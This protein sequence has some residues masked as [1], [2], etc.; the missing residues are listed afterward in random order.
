MR[1]AVAL[2]TV[3]AVVAS[4]SGAPVAADDDPPPPQVPINVQLWTP[5]GTPP[6]VM[7]VEPTTGQVLQLTEMTGGDVASQ[8]FG[9]GQPGVVCLG[10]TGPVNIESESNTSRLVVSTVAAPAL[11]WIADEGAQAVAAFYDVPRDDRVALYGRDEIRAYMANRLLDIV[12]K[13]AYGRTLTADEQRALDYL[14]NQ[15]L[16]LDRAVATAAYREYQ[17]YKAQG[18]GYSPPPAPSF[19]ASPVPLPDAVRTWC[20]S[21]APGM[22]GVF[23]APMPGVDEFQAWGF[24]RAA[25]DLGLDALANPAFRANMSDVIRAGVMAGGAVVAGG[26]AAVTAALVGASEATAT[27]IAG[28]VAP[29]SGVAVSFGVGAAAAVVAVV[30]VAVIALALSIW[31][32]VE[33]EQIGT[34]ITERM[35]AAAA[36]T[37]PF[38]LAA[39][40]TANAGRSLEADRATW[41]DDASKPLYRRSAGYARLVELVTRATMVRSNGS[42]REDPTGI[43]TPNAT[44]P[45]DHRFRVTDASGTVSFVDQIQLPTEGGGTATLRFSRGW[46]VVSQGGG[47]P[48]PALDVGYVDADGTP[49]FATRR[50]DPH[51]SGQLFAITRGG[52]SA[53]VMTSAL[54]Y[55]DAGGGLVTAQIVPPAATAPLG[56]RP[57]VAGSLLPGRVHNLRPNPVSADGRFNLDTFVDDYDYH[58]TVERLDET[59]GAWVA[60]VGVTPV[61]VD[62][63][64][65]YGGAFT[66]TRVG[67]YRARA[68]MEHREGTFP[69]TSGVVE[70]S[71]RAPEIELLHADLVDDHIANA[72]T[73]SVQASES[74]PGDHVT[75]AVQWPGE[76]GSDEPGPIT[77]AEAD[78]VGGLPCATP[79]VTLTHP[80]G[81]LTDLRGDVTVTVTNSHGGA[82]SRKV[83]ITTP[84]RPSFVAP[85]VPPSPDQPGV[86]DFD[87]YVTHVQMP[88]ATEANPNYVVAG[89]VPGASGDPAPSFVVT[90]P[91]NPGPPL[92][93]VDVRGDGRFLVSIGERAGQP[94]VILRGLPRIE[95]IGT[96]EVT[97]VVQ[98]SNGSRSTFVLLIDVVAAPNDAYRA[99]LTSDVDPLDFS[100]DRPPAVVPTLL[101]GRSEWGPYDG[102]MCV[103]LRDDWTTRELCDDVSRFF[104]EEGAALPFPYPA[105]FPHGLAT[106]GGI[107]RAR[108]WLPEGDRTYPAPIEVAFAMRSGSGPPRITD[109]TWDDDEDAATLTVEPFS[110]EVPITSV[111]CRLDGQDVSGCFDVDGGT[112]SPP[113]LTAGAHVLDVLV[114]DERGNYDSATLE[115][116]ASDP[117]DPEPTDPPVVVP[118]QGSVVEG[119]DGTSVLEVPVTLSHPTDHDVAVPWRTLR[120]GGIAF[121]EAT[122]DVDYTAATGTLT[123]PAGE[124]TAVAEIEV[125]GDVDEEVDELVVVSFRDPVGA[126]MGGFWGLGF[127]AIV[128][129]DWPKVVPGAATQSEGDEGDTVVEVPVVL[130]Q[131]SDE[132]VTV[133]WTTLAVGGLA[134]AEADAGDYA[135]AGGTVTFA[136]GQTEATVEVTVHGDLDVEPDELVVI[137]FHSPTGARMGGFWGLGFLTILDDD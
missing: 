30:V 8:C 18:C 136:P 102:A 83:P 120:V 105:L 4:L 78:C 50:P 60:D 13:A 55:R 64:A 106:G 33:H 9:A 127:G 118:G 42:V 123:V 7:T 28:A 15:V 49:A 114:T 86:V 103:G 134:V 81:V 1:W 95:D 58:W 40:R 36:T 112:W 59:T 122:P 77:S 39:L 27:A 73:L 31:Q 107:L 128:D 25:H 22:A 26:A 104:D 91:A 89:I 3:G 11:Q 98:Q 111:T 10:R 121:D 57:S 110:T 115:V 19:V 53:T 129:D 2:G 43:W 92:I 6:A 71:V 14:Q 88:V 82:T 137:S 61:T 16:D 32:L 84:A 51:G 124:V 29:F 68:V 85:P 109:L 45:T 87:G 94:V 93:A 75:V 62:G 108:A 37:D 69:D 66:P 44:T 125:H 117:T 116:E 56:P 126:R 35:N 130:S 65:G 70:F 52:G 54:T 46:M 20:L 90:D 133:E 47:P 41:V 79:F 63:N 21:R 72:L 74:V 131:P 99:G 100:V 132:S 34:T 97:L 17:S 67:Q 12:D 76:L 135:S 38:G 5:L 23:A 48:T 80:L 101:G 119:D 113:P 96:H 24:Y